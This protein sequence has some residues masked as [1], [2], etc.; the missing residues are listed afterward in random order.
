MLFINELRHRK[1]AALSLRHPLDNKDLPA[2]K[3][4]RGEVG[5]CEGVD[6]RGVRVLAALRAV[7]ETPWFMVAKVDQAEV[8]APLHKQTWSVV[9]I[10]ASLA[11]ASCLSTALMW[12]RHDR[13]LIR[14]QLQS[15][16]V[17]RNLAERFEHL[18]QAANDVILIA[19][20][21]WRIV[22]ANR[23]AVESYGY[24]A[25]ELRQMGL[26]HLKTPAT[27]EQVQRHTVRLQAGGRAMYEIIHR[28]KDGSSFPVEISARMVEIGGAVYGMA[29]IRDITRRKAFEHEIERLNCLYATLS[30]INQMVVRAQSQPQL[31]QEAVDILANYGRFRLV[32]AGRLVPETQEVVPV[33]RAGKDNGYIDQI[34]VYG[35]SRPEGSGPVGTSIREGKPCVF[36]DFLH[37]PAAQPWHDAALRY[38]LRAA[39]ALPIRF[40]G[41]VWGA[42]AVYDS[43]AG[44]FQDKEVA[45]LEEAALDISYAMDNLQKEQQRQHAEAAQAR[46]LRILES[47]L[48]EIYIFD[49]ESLRFEYANQGALRNLGYPLD[50]LRALTPLELKPEFTDVSFREAIR[51]LLR[52]E[53]EQ[54]TYF[55]V[56][57]RANGS[58]YPVEAHLQLVEH[59]GK[60][61][62][63]AI[64]MD[65]TERKQAQVELA[66]RVEELQA[67]N[68]ELERWNRASVDRE[69]RMVELKKQVNQLNRQ[70][71]K[72]PPYPLDFTQRPDQSHT[73]RP[74]QTTS[75]T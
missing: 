74:T 6:Y 33:A 24:T 57:R 29:I 47:S 68:E 18:M 43:E 59:E 70:V 3:A 46:L 19:D 72:A 32:W 51:P 58:L 35:D 50:V 8:Y 21:D 42:F 27:H 56:H 65:I 37:A 26:S 34:K 20:K 1:G 49:A 5:V 7:P 66:R 71:G 39:A 2:S 11:L 63:L 4:A 73:P 60:K 61:S 38:G 54:L 23:R 31:L 28:R 69:L 53:K 14:Q 36:N 40:N 67:R 55:T 25:D 30:Q 10:M 13:H 17:Q 75:E 12:W 48:N 45:L 15:E 9:I 64:I 41:E 52:R 22:D 16:Q 62:F 44:V